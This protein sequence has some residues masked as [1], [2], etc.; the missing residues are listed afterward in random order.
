M[1]KLDLN[2]P[3]QVAPANFAL[4]IDAVRAPNGAIVCRST[5]T[6]PTNG[7]VPYNLYGTGVNSAAAVRYV[8]GSGAVDFRDE[9][10]DREG[11]DDS[12]E[13][14]SG[15]QDRQPDG[16]DRRERGGERG[17]GEADHERREQDRK[18]S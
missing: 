5:L 14:R 3:I 15:D 4:A 17:Q 10:R 16:D 6:A 2:S 11:D 7:C 9:R 18:E 8:L 13:H 12:G 1:I